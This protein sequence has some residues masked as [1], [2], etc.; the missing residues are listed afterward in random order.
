MDDYEQHHD[1]SRLD[2]SEAL[3]RPLRGDVYFS[4]QGRLAA[5]RRTVRA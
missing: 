2:E 5:L 4:L 3:I 1:A